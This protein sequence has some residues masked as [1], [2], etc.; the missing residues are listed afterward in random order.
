[1]RIIVDYDPVGGNITSENGQMY[2]IG[3][4][5]IFPESKNESKELTQ[6]SEVV[7]LSNNGMTANDLIK[8]RKAGVI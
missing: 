3:P 2:Y 5:L 6:Q 7:A 1:M 8:M 4:G